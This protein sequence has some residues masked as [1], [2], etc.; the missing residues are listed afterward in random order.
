MP[1]AP[2][3]FNSTA[4]ELA[5]IAQ[6]ALEFARSGGATSAEVDVSQGVGQNVSVRKG[7]IE[8]IEYNRDNGL[9]LTVYIGLQRG[10]ASTS[11][12]SVEALRA[13]VEKALAIARYTAA[14]PAAGLADSALLARD[15]SDLDLYHPWDIAV[16]DAAELARRCEAAAFAVDPRIRNSEGATVSTYES[17]FIYANSNGFCGG[18]RG[19]RHGTSCAV[20]AEQAGAMQRDYWYSTARATQALEPVETVGRRAGERAVRRLG[21]RKIGTR[22]TPVVFE[23]SLAAG[24]IGHFVGAVT[25]GS[26]YRR[27]SFLMDSIGEQ[28]FAPIVHMREAPHLSRALAS[29]PFDDEGVATRAR[30]IVKE[31]VVQGYFLGSYSARKLN[32][33]STGNAGG[34]HNLLIEH[35][36]E[37]LP[38]LLRRMG[39]GIF[40]TELMGQGVNPVTGDYSR[41]AAGFWVEHG[42][43]QYPVEE[44]TVAGNL[45]QM[46]RDVVAIGSDVETRG[47]KQVGSILISNITLAGN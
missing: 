30:D 8:T 33:Q 1:Q 44:V 28:V 7:E 13:T 3:R 20:I 40:V 47:S 42:E 16:E 18:Y 39:T 4:D 35:G 46:F 21:A 36:G 37:D 31:G 27:A 12:C 32:M 41:G 19:S 34:N 9:S 15:W 14:D 26:L 43:V 5:A 24:L 23:A 6:R 22:Q 2:S 17:Q 38:A 29:A 11:D 25:G 10:H 45:K